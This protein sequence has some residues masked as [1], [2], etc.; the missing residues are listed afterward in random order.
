MNKVIDKLAWIFIED[1][2]LLMVRSK[3]KELFYLPG[4]KREA[5]ESDEQAL[6][7]EIKEEISVDL[8]PDSIKYVETFTGQADGKAEG[9]SVQLTCYL[10]DYTGELA[11]DAEIEELKFVD[12]NDRAVC[13]LA[14]LVALDWLEANQY[15]P[16]ISK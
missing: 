16:L 13:S 10:A 1:G 2:K 14:A 8:I 12:G 9:V 5:G 11:P 6:V 15:L 4:G 7:R 3:G